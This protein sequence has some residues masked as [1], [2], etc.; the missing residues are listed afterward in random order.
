MPG[1]YLDYATT[2]SFQ[3]LSSSSFIHHST[4]LRAS[5]IKNGTVQCT[6]RTDREP[7]RI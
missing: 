7:V 1:Q 5:K 2:T 6:K 3:I 4:L